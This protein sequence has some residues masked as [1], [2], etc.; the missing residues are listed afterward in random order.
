MKP[1]LNRYS[2]QFGYILL[3]LTLSTLV[4]CALLLWSFP[5]A[6]LTFGGII[7]L[8]VKG[9]VFDLGVALFFTLAYAIY[10]LIL[11]QKLNNTLF[12]RIFT[13]FGFFL[14]VLITIFSFF[15][16]FT[17]W[18]EYAARFDFI[19]VDYL[20]Y[21]YEVISNINQSYPL[22][23]LI[24]GVLL[25][26][27]GITWLAARRGM[28]KASFQSYTPFGKRLL[29]TVFMV[30]AIAAHLLLI[31][32]SW[33]ETGKNRYQQELSKAGIYSFVSAFVNNEL[34]YDKYYLMEDN[35]AVF[36]EMR[37]LLQAGNS[38]FLENGSSIYRHISDTATTSR[39]NVIMVTIES[40]SADF[41]ARFGSGRNITPVLDSIAKESILFTNLYATGTRT[42]RGMEAL[43]LAVPPTPG[44]SIVRR[45]NNEG[46][47]SL[48]TIFEKA[49]YDRTFFYGG[50]GYFDNMNQFFGNNGFDI[51]DRL[52]HRLVGDNFPTK[53]TNF[54]DSEVQFENA[55]GV[56]DED[57]YSAVIRNADEKY[58]AGK[59]FFDFVMTVSNH[60]PFTYPDGKI[61]IP[62]HTGRDGA[63]KYTDYAIGAF[64]RQIKDKP[65]FKNTVI[66][67]VADHCASSAG[68]NEIEVNK[69]H[70]PCMVYNVPGQAPQEISAMCSQLDIYP[71][72]LGLLHW[73]Y[74]SN[75]YGKN[76]LDSA[77]QPR[78]MISTYQLLGYLEPGKLIIL[79]PQQKAQS[80][81]VKPGS[82][83]LQSTAMDSSLLKKAV[84]NY[85]SAYT[86]FK[87]GGMR[88]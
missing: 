60:R 32:N 11:P 27:G 74:D 79:S 80:F 42:V 20:L 44:Q 29:L 73:N 15:A 30:G 33:A 6:G 55:W 54:K 2:V 72:L 78:A 28:F 7:S 4:R 56:C 13:Y 75:L 17:F 47:F 36:R 83:D 25:A 22:P 49:G 65:W 18:G 64:L 12:N 34:P 58:A 19:A 1:T 38:S 71:T 39:P 53:R 63:V 37:A 84:A 31:S 14:A 76:V 87:N 45:K 57:I 40:F 59:P 85:Q 77:Y 3:Y 50:D 35:N 46:L 68:K 52:R 5:D 82:G 48:S 23:L 86:L 88:K 43:T 10:L 62:S 51:H 66:V 81:V 41:M 67:F 21:T 8:F 61:D 70:I 9:F 16:E 26:T 24:G 69:Y